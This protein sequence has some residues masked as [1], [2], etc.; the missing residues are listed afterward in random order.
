MKFKTNLVVGV[1]FAALFAFVYMYEIRGGEDR[2][3]QAARSKQL[4]EFKESE[5]KRIVIGRGDTTIVLAKDQGNWAI[6]API[7]DGADTDA[8][9]RY[10]RNIAES[11][12]EKI[13]AD[14][15]EAS[16]PTLASRYGFSA[17]RLQVL[18]ET[19]DGLLDTLLFGADTPTDRYTYVKQSGSNPEIFA[20]RAWRFDNLDKGVMDLRNRRVMDLVRGEVVAARRQGT[21]GDIALVKEGEEWLLSVPLNARAAADAV[22]ALLAK[23]EASQVEKFVDEDPDARALAEYG[24]AP[25]AQVEWTLLAGSERAE[26]RLSIGRDD[27]EGRYYARGSERPQVF[28]VD[29]TLVQKLT[30]ASDELRD[31]KPL[32]LER[33]AITEIALSRAD[34]LVLH[35]DKDST[36][37]WSLVAPEKSE[38]KSWK[39]N[40]LLTDLSE[41]EATAFSSAQGGDLLLSIEL[42]SG[43]QTLHL[44]RFYSRDGEVFLEQNDDVAS[45]RIDSDNFAEVD[46]EFDEIQ[47]LRAATDSTVVGK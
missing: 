33:D 6:S 10:L 28:L 5:V 39:L 42:G 44:L 8:V 32:R 18:L 36:G 38:A 2:R 7:K 21:L 23:I 41:L 25:A 40:S 13:V 11:E 14:S 1:I 4:L 20:V 3:Q 16:D 35:A 30:Q 19:E 37:V 9:V 15:S 22:E 47:Q 34:A 26:K 12:R 29:S 27:G 31:K 17:P 46:V 24:L 43:E 45:Y